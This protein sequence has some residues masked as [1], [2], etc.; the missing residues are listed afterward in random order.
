[1]RHETFPASAPGADDA[2]MA[3]QL[4]RLS[5]QIDLNFMPAGETLARLVDT[6][7]TVLSGLEGIGR[8]LGEDSADANAGRNLLAAAHSLTT[9]PER[10]AHRGA[11]VAR[12]VAI[13]QRLSTS[14]ADVLRLLTIL[15][16][17]TVNLKIAAA[18]ADEF[19][20]FASDM[21]AK[22][23]VG[24]QQVDA[25]TKQVKAMLTSLGEM[26]GV[27]ELLAR[28]CARVVPAVPDRLSREVE[29]L[30]AWQA[31][32]ARVSDTARAIMM[33]LQ[34][35]V[36]KALEAIQIGDITR[37]R[38]DHVATG[39]EQ[40]DI[41]LAGDIADPAGTRAHMQHLL[42][43]QLEDLTADFSQQSQALLAALDGLTPDCD[44]LL[45]GQRVGLDDSGEFLGELDACISGAQ[46]M[47]GQLRRADVKATEIS[48]VVI[49]ASAVLRDRVAVIERLRFDVDYMAINVNIQARRDARIG[50]P[51]A[52]IADEIRIC[53][54]QMASLAQDIGAI[55]EELGQV[56][57]AFESE[58]TASEGSIDE[59]LAAALATVR[60]GARAATSAMAGLD[61]G[62]QNIVGTIRA[63]VDDLAICKDLVDQLQATAAVLFATA[64]DAQPTADGEHPVEALMQ[65][66]GRSYT[67]ISERQVHDRFLLPGMTP[68]AG[69]STGGFGFD[70]DD[71][72]EFG[73][74]FL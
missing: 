74:V 38:L 42:A 11:Q 59:A 6:V 5:G 3:K 7:G 68:L 36:G 51:V 55:A 66:L 28:E 52:V 50:R 21:N 73:E 32:L 56:S 8:A 40:L 58:L 25:F 54:R 26:R 27:D 41:A 60:D 62:A 44:A 1:M 67:M 71:D 12:M 30:Q 39:C 22:L 10:Q 4:A 15:R 29:R 2:D 69:A 70:N 20:E 43:A 72:D 64:G 63:T 48:D 14:A 13:T 18:G 33:R 61:S 57:H 35:G 23:D 9:A 65:A 49:K 47:T 19:M 46:G 17:Y 31:N 24:T 16:F 34:T 37:Q 45:N 53:S